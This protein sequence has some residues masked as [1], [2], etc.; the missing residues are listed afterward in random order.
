MDLTT[1]FDHIAEFL[2]SKE[3][4][5]VGN[6][7]TFQGTDFYFQHPLANAQGILS[8]DWFNMSVVFTGID[9]IHKIVS[10]ENDLKLIYNHDNGGIEDSNIPNPVL[11][12]MWKKRIQNQ[13]NAS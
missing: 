1:L 4:I 3:F 12:E 6:R 13:I 2:L 5:Y 11:L 10:V 7:I 8:D 9:V